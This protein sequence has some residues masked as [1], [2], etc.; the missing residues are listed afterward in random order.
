[1]LAR[2]KGVDAS[3][4]VIG[5]ALLGLGLGVAMKSDIWVG[6]AASCAAVLV[7]VA[8]GLITAR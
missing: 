5:G 3:D 2:L 4:V 6:L 7:L 8:I 1:M